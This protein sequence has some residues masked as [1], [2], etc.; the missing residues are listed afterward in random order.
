[1]KAELHRLGYCKYGKADD[2]ALNFM[3]ADKLMA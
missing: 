1:M 2:I 3:I